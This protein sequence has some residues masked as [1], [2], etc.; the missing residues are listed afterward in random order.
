MALRLLR[1]ASDKA[2]KKIAAK[3]TAAAK[4]AAAKQKASALSRKAK[5]AR[6][7]SALRTPAAKA[8]TKTS[9]QG[10]PKTSKAPQRLKTTTKTSNT[11]KSK[12]SPS[13]TVQRRNYRRS[14]SLALK[15][16]Q[17]AQKQARAERRG[18]EVDYKTTSTK[19]AKSPTPS[20]T[21]SR[22]TKTPSQ[23]KA[24][25]RG[26]P[27]RKPANKTPA[28]RKTTG[29]TIDDSKSNKLKNT[30]PT[31]NKRQTPKGTNPSQKVTGDVEQTA[32]NARRDSRS[33]FD[34]KARAVIQQR[35]RDSGL[36]G[37]D[38]KYKKLKRDL[39]KKAK[40][41]SLRVGDAA[42]AK[43]RS[44][45][46]ANLNQS[47]GKAYAGDSRNKAGFRNQVGNRDSNNRLTGS[48]IR[49]LS[50]DMSARKA[51]GKLPP[52]K[53]SPKYKPTESRQSSETFNRGAYNFNNSRKKAK[54]KRGR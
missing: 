27:F 18:T 46:K 23:A 30:S 4:K 11:I 10:K 48:K 31:G 53:Q 1:R 3:G 47:P 36:R 32:R 54:N 7:R 33:S 37:G 29:R 9:M 39:E 44:S 42:E 45:F 28:K 35:L 6:E 50:E 25:K 43:T 16:R 21:A 17:A 52:I 49:K 13:K 20:K 51:A 41:G 34:A 5:D 2:R 38:P 26:I 14:S 40:E 19:G 8:R 24:E 12:Q 22:T 15:R